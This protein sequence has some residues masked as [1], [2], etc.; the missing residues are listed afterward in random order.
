MLLGNLAFRFFAFLLHPHAISGLLIMIKAIAT[1][2]SRYIAVDKILRLAL[3]MWVA[4]AWCWVMALLH[5]SIWII[6]AGL[7]MVA[8]GMVVTVWCILLDDVLNQDDE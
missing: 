7:L 4:S 3:V 6:P 5:Q 1:Y 8:A 2:L